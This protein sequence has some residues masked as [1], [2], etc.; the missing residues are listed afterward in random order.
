MA[1]EKQSRKR[2]RREEGIIIAGT[3]ITNQETKDMSELLILK[4]YGVQI[5]PQLGG[6]IETAKACA[7]ES[8]F[9]TYHMNKPNVYV[10]DKNLGGREVSYLY[11]LGSVDNKPYYRVWSLTKIDFTQKKAVT[12]VHHTEP[13]EDLQDMARLFRDESEKRGISHEVIPLLD[14]ETT[15]LRGNVALITKDTFEFCDRKGNVI[16]NIAF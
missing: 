13:Y 2:N 11:F 12:Y 16:K 9:I 15:V 6:Y 1:Q 8:A 10:C 14:F 5:N 7:D 4:K 3:V